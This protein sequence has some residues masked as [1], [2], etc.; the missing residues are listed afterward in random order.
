MHHLHLKVVLRQAQ[1]RD[2][3]GTSSTNLFSVKGD[4]SVT[5]TSFSRDGSGLTGV[6]VAGTSWDSWTPTLSGSSTSIDHAQHKI[7]DGNTVS[8][9][10]KFSAT[11]GLSDTSI[12]FTV[13]EEASDTTEQLWITDQLRV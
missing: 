13:P 6:T 3:V 2:N 5:A 12:S 4:G 1:I 8:F 7:I 10:I 9:S 11:T